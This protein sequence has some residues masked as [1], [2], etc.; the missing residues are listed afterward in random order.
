MNPPEKINNLVV[1]DLPDKQ[2][3]LETVLAGLGENVVT[4]RSG[5]EALRR[6]LE[7]DFAVILLDV[8]M[9][10]MDGL[11]TAA[12]I[13]GRKKTQHTPIIFVTAFD[14]EKRLTQGYSLGA[15]DYILSPVSPEVL[16]TK[17]GVFVSLY[18]M[19]R[20]VERQAEERVAL[21]RAQAA[22]AAAEEAARRLHFLA[23]AG[24]A[25]GQSLEASAVLRRLAERAVPFLADSAAAVLIDPDGGWRRETAGGAADAAAEDLLRRA[26]TEGRRF[27]SKAPAPAIP[28]RRS[29]CGR[30]GGCWGRWP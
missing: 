7:Q 10:D 13:R 6:L 21:A 4:A 14:D 27:F 1:D 11:E 25:L 16:R 19:Q 2:L 28:P 22:R 29:R 5:R 17:V 12:L 9:P 8:N 3:A 26:N 30:A 20:Q 23:E 15:V 24:S 18:L